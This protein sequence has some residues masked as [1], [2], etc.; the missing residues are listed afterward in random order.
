M[1]RNIEGD[2]LWDEDE[3]RDNDRDMSPEEEERFLEEMRAEQE[4]E[5]AVENTQVV[6]TGGGLWTN[7]NIFQFELPIDA[8]QPTVIITNETAPTQL[9]GFDD[10]GAATVKEEKLRNK[11]TSDY[12]AES[13]RKVGYATTS[14]SVSKPK[15][16][17]PPQPTTTKKVVKDDRTQNAF[18]NNNISYEE[19]KT[20]ILTG[21]ADPFFKDTK[22]SRRKAF[23]NEEIYINFNELADELARN[24]LRIKYGDKY[25][26]LEM[27]E[28]WSELTN[29]Y[30]NII[31]KH[32]RDEN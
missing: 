11:D 1:N 22:V 28:E 7:E 30:I 20:T 25:N 15:Y 14:K 31:L 19:Y 27:T 9:P 8:P 6:G 5:K 29:K 13:V 16:S 26:E 2:S 17:V 12:L 23:K 18:L 4:A 24:D 10:N 21:S 32:E 3:P